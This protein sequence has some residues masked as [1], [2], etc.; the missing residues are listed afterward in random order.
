MDNALDL[1]NSLFESAEDNLAT[2]KL[3]LFGDLASTDVS[4]QKIFDEVNLYASTG[5]NARVKSSQIR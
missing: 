1:M 5:G 4:A 2:S 3:G